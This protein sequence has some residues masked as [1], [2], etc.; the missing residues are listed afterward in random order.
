MKR[1]T[2]SNGAIALVL[3]SVLAISWALSVGGQSLETREAELAAMRAQIDRLRERLGSITSREASLSDR[4][5][6][7]ETE[8][9]LQQMRLDEA[10]AAAALAAERATDAERRIA[11]LTASMDAVRG[12]LRRRLAG[13]Y[14]LG[15]Q[16]YIRLFFALRPE[17]E[18]LPAIRQLRFLALR[19]RQAIERWTLLRRELAAQRERLETQ[20]QEMAAWADEERV[21]RDDL[22]SARARHRDVLESVARERRALTARTE[23]LENKERKLARFVAALVDDEAQRLDGTPIQDFRGVLDWPLAGEIEVEIEFGPRRDPRYRTEVPHSGLG[24]ATRQGD[25][26]RTVYPG[27][28]LYADDFDGY[29]PTVIVHHPGRVFTLYAGLSLLNVDRGDVLSLGD[30]IG[31]ADASLYFEIRLENEPEDPRRWLR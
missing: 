31:A 6:R 26:V 28:V 11:E 15:R 27:E 14:R 4:L 1:W 22:A 20:R 9:E 13:L 7:V 8:L 5:A 24:L 23:E 2:R 12:D 19:D 18:V 25:R 3:L 29:G 16:G 21:R 10:L 30:V 17:Q